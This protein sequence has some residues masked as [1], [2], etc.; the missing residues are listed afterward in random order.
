M[1]ANKPGFMQQTG[2]L[3]FV[4]SCFLLLSAFRHTEVDSNTYPDFDG[5]K[6]DTV[7]V[8]IPINNPYFRDLVA[9]KL[10]KSFKRMKIR[11][12]TDDDL[13]SPFETWTAQSKEKVLVQQGVDAI[14]MISVAS[15]SNQVGP[16]VI[17]YDGSSYNG[18]TIGMATQVQ[19]MSEQ[20]TFNIRLIDE[21]SRELVWTA[22]LETRG[23]GTLFVGDKST[24]KAVAHHLM[25]S[26]KKAGHLP[27]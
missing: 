5:Y 8:Q 25:K 18:S 10:A 16:G 3:M 13:F 4:L 12:L 6:F 2:K 9:E 11:M 17:L 20:S 7:F 19:K 23:N 15:V 1:N 24:A 14:I 26:L 22:I 21:S 27:I